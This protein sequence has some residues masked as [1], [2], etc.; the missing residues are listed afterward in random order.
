MKHLIPQGL[1]LACVATLAACATPQSMAPNTEQMLAAA[2]F[3]EKPADT[4]ARQAKLAAL[5]PYQILSQ[6]VTVGGQDTVGYVYADPTHCHCVFVGNPQTYQRFQQYAFQQRMSQD[7]IAAQEMAA[8][9]GWGWG[10][11]GPYPFWGDGVIV[12]GGGYGGGF[13]GG[14]HF[15]GR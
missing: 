13:H 1:A 14:G 4:P 2:G 8:N 3:L 6:R 11:W 10:D 9:Y 5:P 15:H 12:V 7:Q